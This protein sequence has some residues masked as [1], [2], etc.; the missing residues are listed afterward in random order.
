MLISMDTDMLLS[1]LNLKL[2]D[3]FNSLEDLC[4][5]IGI[6]KEEV[7]EKLESTGYTYDKKTNQFK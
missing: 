1:I 6:S 2:R 4:D 7:L 5:D 3:Y